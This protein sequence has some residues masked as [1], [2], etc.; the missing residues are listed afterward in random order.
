[1]GIK[2][3]T[4]LIMLTPLLSFNI[5]KA[6]ICP[7]PKAFK[8]G[9]AFQ[10]TGDEEVKTP[11]YYTGNSDE[12]PDFMLQGKPIKF[13]SAIFMSSKIGENPN[14]IKGRLFSC[15]YYVE[16]ALKPKLVLPQVAQ[17]RNV[18][19]LLDSSSKWKKHSKIKRRYDCFSDS[20][21][22]CPFSLDNLIK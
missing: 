1:M 5:A 11:V 12:E 8:E 16:G 21:K 4:I 7:N 19:I 15:E 14:E 6:D 22:N 9:T 13:S 17:Y 18:S 3:L 20:V 2:T 10:I